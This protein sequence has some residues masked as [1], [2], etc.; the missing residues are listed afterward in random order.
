MH[1]RS[2]GQKKPVIASTA[3]VDP[4]AV[5][6]GEVS[7]AENVSIWPGAVLRGDIHFIRV[8]RD[9]NIQDGT[10]IHVTHASEYN[11]MGFPVSI[12][13]QVTIGHRV[14]LHGCTV[15]DRVLVGMNSTVLDGAVLQPGCM[16][17]AHSLVPPNK[18]LDVGY[19]YVGS[20]VKKVR[21]LT[22]KEINFLTYSAENYVELSKKF[23]KSE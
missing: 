1:I 15:G 12:G 14:V 11:E 5:V 8:G 9:T 4:A 18:V 2:F 7:L 21:P 19:L 20:P 22:E 3:Y 6:I 10:V 17:G 23:L 13:E 16:V